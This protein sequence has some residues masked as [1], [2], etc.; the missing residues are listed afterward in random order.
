M[1]E[2]SQGTFHCTKLCTESEF[3]CNSVRA[4]EDFDFFLDEE[5]DE[6][7]SF[8]VKPGRMGNRLNAASAR[9]PTTEELDEDQGPDR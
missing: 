1:I 3:S 6:D 4:Q 2:P 5:D 7:E 8:P 9:L